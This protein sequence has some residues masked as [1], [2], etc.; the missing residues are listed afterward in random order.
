[1]VPLLVLWPCSVQKG[2][3]RL[4]LPGTSAYISYVADSYLSTPEGQAEA[5]RAKR[6]GSRAY[7][8][9]K[10]VIL[11]P[12]VAGGVVGAGM[13]QQASPRFLRCVDQSDLQSTS[14]SL[15]PSVTSPTRTGTDHGTTEP[16]LLSPLVWW[17]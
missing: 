16:S 4:D 14:Q 3:F 17:L 5:E 2:K 8:Q 9:A 15:V 11:R 7:M 10:E 6:E 12:K 13:L 1:V